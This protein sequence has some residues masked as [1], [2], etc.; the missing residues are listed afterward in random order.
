MHCT[1]VW[2][3]GCFFYNAKGVVTPE[4]KQK[5]WQCWKDNDRISCLYCLCASSLQVLCLCTDKSAIKRHAH[6]EHQTSLA[7]WSSAGQTL[8]EFQ[9]AHQSDADMLRKAQNKANCI[10]LHIGWMTALYSAKKTL[11]NQCSTKI[12]ATFLAVF[13]DQQVILNHAGHIA[14]Q[15]TFFSF[16]NSG[17]TR[18]I[19]FLWLVKR[20]VAL[21]WADVSTQ[22]LLS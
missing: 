22:Q 1:Q 16:N 18:N 19:H 12:A 9:G 15:C 17:T 3:A 10:E 6:T 2:E 5:A 4:G 14:P 13:W 7:G 20:G 8:P 21:R 11:Q